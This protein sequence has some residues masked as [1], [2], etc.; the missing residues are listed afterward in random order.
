[1]NM[2]AMIRLISVQVLAMNMNIVI[3]SHHLVAL[4]FP[5]L[6]LQPTTSLLR[7]PSIERYHG[8]YH[9]SVDTATTS[10][11]STTTSKGRFKPTTTVT[12]M[13]RLD[14]FSR[15]SRWDDDA[16]LNAMR[17]GP[18]INYNNIDID[19]S[20]DNMNMNMDMNNQPPYSEFYD[21]NDQEAGGYSPPPRSSLPLSIDGSSRSGYS[22][23]SSSSPS[24]NNQ[25]RAYRESKYRRNPEWPQNNNVNNNTN[26]RYDDTNKSFGN[27]L[28]QQQRQRDI[29]DHYTDTDTD[30]SQQTSRGS[31]RGQPI[32]RGASIGEKYTSD[33]PK[34]SNQSGGYNSYRNVNQ[35]GSSES[36]STR[37]YPREPRNNYTIG[38]Q[39]Q[40][41]QQD[42]QQQIDARILNKEQ[43]GGQRNDNGSRVQRNRRQSNRSYYGGNNMNIGDNDIY[44]ND[45][46]GRLETDNERDFGRRSFDKYGTGGGLYQREDFGL[47]SFD[48]EYYDGP[49]SP[50][51][52]M[53]PSSSAS[54]WDTERRKQAGIGGKGSSNSNSSFGKQRSIGSF[55]NSN[56]RRQQDQRLKLRSSTPSTSYNEPRQ[57]D[58][59]YKEPESEFG[60]YKPSDAFGG[61]DQRPNYFEIKERQQQGAGTTFEQRRRGAQRQ[62]QQRNT[63]RS[64]GKGMDYEELGPPTMQSSFQSTYSEQREPTMPPDENDRVR[65]M[66]RRQQSFG[67]QQQQSIG[68][69]NS[70]DRQQ[71]QK[72]DLPQY[73]AWQPSSDVIRDD[74]PYYYDSNRRQQQPRQEQLQPYRRGASVGRTSAAARSLKKED[75]NPI[76]N[77]LDNV[78]KPSA[79]DKMMD[80]VNSDMSRSINAEKRLT[81]ALLAEARNNLLADP[82]VRSTLGTELVLGTL[83][84]KST[85][86]TTVNDVTR[87]RL[88]LVIPVSGSL[89]TGRIQLVADQD[90]ILELKLDVNG[91]VIDVYLDME[92][93]GPVIDLDIV[94]REIY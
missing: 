32:R 72:Q 43:L 15:R 73:Q 44:Y 63:S 60:G 14:D 59:G 62:Q 94:D 68:S 82:A 48:Y 39:K 56:L 28:E 50:S 29:D 52:M 18:G 17:Y 24:F 6:Q 22:S 57:G 27:G 91:F 65:I 42:S 34:G 3:G 8:R 87:S 90:G 54:V 58:F 64:R 85:S 33:F 40:Q 12:L 78:L 30:S 16:D 88:Q 71:Q 74:P 20:R 19:I 79:Q 41:Q 86:S 84:S 75:P 23:S 77:W 49:S 26:R 36:S 25:Q 9:V 45:N 66:G 47:D 13:S 81:K 1:M 69:G 93:Q 38:Q 51:E 21:D 61:N 89:S 83:L 70:F 67:Q 53:P 2:K 55:I 10:S 7:V 5:S 35:V 80:R 11:S 4:A 92:E 37:R 76:K 46:N 31:K